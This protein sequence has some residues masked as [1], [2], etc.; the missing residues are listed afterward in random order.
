M[1]GRRWQQINQKIIFR[2]IPHAILSWRYLLPNQSR[3]TRLHKQTFKN[4]WSRFP[5]PVWWL[6]ATYSCTLWYL[7]YGW[8]QT[9]R[10]WRNIRPKHTESTTLSSNRQL[11]ALWWLAFGHAIPPSFY[12]RYQ[13]YRLPE[14]EWLD[15]IY[16]HELPHWHVSQSPKITQRELELISDKELFS[17]AVTNIGLPAIQ[18]VAYLPKNETLQPSQ[19]YQQRSLFIK[20]V[21]GSRKE[22]CY[23]LRYNPEEEN[24][25]L[26]GATT[27]ND[28]QVIL[29][30][31]QHQLNAQ[32][33]LLQPL[34]INHPQI[35]AHTVNSQLVTI[36][37]I[38]AIQNNQAEAI[39]AVLEIPLVV[40]E[41]TILPLSINISTGKIS[42][43]RSLSGAQTEKHSQDVKMISGQILPEWSTVIST[44]QQAHTLF[45]NIKTIGWD[46][47][48]T[49][50]GVI[51]IEGNFNWGV[52]VHQTDGSPLIE[53]INFKYS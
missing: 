31:L 49:D 7:W 27:S 48:I 44:A 38:T 34:L 30:L 16:T 22:G 29:N 37:L 40:T 13:L 46:L 14:R 53:K 35:A 20:P 52:A 23:E 21:I 5:R 12:Y 1:L 51:L 4:A 24:Y 50:K 36:R 39:S 8:F 15:F 11:M 25:Q 45:P 33:L 6:I 42:R 43:L 28:Q 18:T 2:K 17:K 3:S 26:Q 10:V 41:K 32:P 47:A 9:F 19:L